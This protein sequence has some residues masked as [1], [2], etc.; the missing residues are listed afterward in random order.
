[1]SKLRQEDMLSYYF[2]RSLQLEDLLMKKY[3]IP[4]KLLNDKVLDQMIKDF[5]KTCREHIRDLSDKMSRL[6]VQ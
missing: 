1:M 6:G 5:K 4:K 3:E 2:N